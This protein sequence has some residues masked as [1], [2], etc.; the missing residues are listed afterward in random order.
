[1]HQTRPQLFDP[2]TRQRGVTE[3]IAK[4]RLGHLRRFWRTSLHVL[5]ITCVHLINGKI[6]YLSRAQAR[7]GCCR[8]QVIDQVRNVPSLGSSGRPRR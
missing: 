8:N 4:S 6:A 1:M 7:D 3:C 5:A 2:A